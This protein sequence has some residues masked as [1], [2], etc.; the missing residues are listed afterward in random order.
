MKNVKITPVYD[1]KLSSAAV[2]AVNNGLQELLMG[3]NPEA[4]AKKI[5]DAQA[6]ALGK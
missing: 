4:I 5:Q 2:E 1:S 6:R 3:G